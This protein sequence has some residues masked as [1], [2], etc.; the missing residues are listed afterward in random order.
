MCLAFI[1]ASQR[2]LE[3]WARK[4]EQ[5]RLINALCRFAEMRGCEMPYRE[6]LLRARCLTVAERSFHYL[7]VFSIDSSRHDKCWRGEAWRLA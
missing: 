2:L 3:S 7:F 1:V 5:M 4:I 6:D